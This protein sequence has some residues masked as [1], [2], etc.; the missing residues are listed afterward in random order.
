MPVAQG[1]AGLSA[2]IVLLLT[3][4]G[5]G[6]G[7]GGSGR[8]DQSGASTADRSATDGDLTAR[9]RPPGEDPRP[10]EAPG[11]QNLSVGAARQALL[12]V[13][14]GYSPKRPAPLVV[15]L[16]GAN[17]NARAGITP[18]L[19][20]ADKAELLLLAPEARGS[21]WDVIVDDYGPDVAAIDALLQTVFERFSVD[22]SRLAVGGFSDGA[23]YA[24]SLGLANGDLFTHLIAFSP[25][26]TAPGKRRG[27]PR[28]FVSHGV[29]DRVLPI[30]RCSRRIVKALRGSG[31][32]LDYRE[33]DGGHTVPPDVAREAVEWLAHAR[34]AR[35]SAAPA[36]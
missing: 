25:G 34:R 8:S 14:S 21:T 22:R 32:E 23:S 2:V 20:L 10:R 3:G 18:L 4:C 24:L 30:D 29:A 31:Y 19:G 17:S 1:P 6:D 33:F 5:G 35:G 16:H 9:P 28:I 26:F 27:R 12:Y 36:G 11:L 13:P 7:G 15:L